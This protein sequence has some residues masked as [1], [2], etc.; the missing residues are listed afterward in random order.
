MRKQKLVQL[1]RHFALGENDFKQFDQRCYAEYDFVECFD[2][3]H[4]DDDNNPTSDSYTWYVPR[5]YKGR[6]PAAGEYARVENLDDEAVVLI[7]SPVYTLTKEQHIEAI[8][9]YCALIEIVYLDSDSE[10]L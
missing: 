1:V 4:I 6:M 8:H 3:V 5:D 10:E 9:P 2:A 7:V